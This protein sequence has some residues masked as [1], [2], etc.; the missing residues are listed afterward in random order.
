MNPSPQ[1]KEFLFLLLAIVI[2]ALAGLGTLGFVFVSTYIQYRDHPELYGVQLKWEVLV[3]LG[4][5]ELLE[6]E[7]LEAAPD[8]ELLV[9]LI[10]LPLGE[11]IFQGTGGELLCYIW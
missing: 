6:L 5:V 8:E 7:E 10:G 9:V 11:L 2:G 4:V 1:T 3:L